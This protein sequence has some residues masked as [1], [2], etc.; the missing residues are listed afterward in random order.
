MAGAEGERAD[1]AE[2]AIA[3]AYARDEND[4]FIAPTV[5]GDYAGMADGD[6]LFCIN[7]RADRAREILAAFAAPDFDGFE[8]SP[9][10][11]AA[12]TGMVEYSQAHNAYMDAVFPDQEI[13]DTL[14]QTVARAGLHQLR[15]AET[16]KYPHVTFFFNGGVE[17][18]EPHETRHMAPSPKVATYDLQ[19]EMSEAEVTEC[20]VS[21]IRS[22]DYDLIVTNYANPDMVGHTGD[23]DAAI[24]AVEAV[25]AGLGKAVAAIEE[26]GGAMLICADHGNC[27]TMIDPETGG[28]HTAHTL[29]PV[30]VWLAGRAGASLRDGRL[31]DVAPT[32]L[33]LL[34]VAQPAAMTGTS[35]MG[36]MGEGST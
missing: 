5:I 12:R 15:I 1:T 4:E 7:F 19:P 9:I 26:M 8:R 33:A 29:N 27:E 35:L 20:L 13:V 6:G 2:N 36:L 34:G 25:D 32:L 17:T 31:A 23:L 18:P 16:E 22:G 30:P 11:F 3:A 21:A 28:A 24:S 14:G 10:T